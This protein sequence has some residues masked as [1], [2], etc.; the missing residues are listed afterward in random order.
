MGRLRFFVKEEV[1]IQLRAERGS[2]PRRIV[3]W[4]VQEKN[5][6]IYF[7]STERDLVRHGLAKLMRVDEVSRS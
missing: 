7:A 1:D 2:S 4:W 3:P 6:A 5:A